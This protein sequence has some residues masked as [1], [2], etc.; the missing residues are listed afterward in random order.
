MGDLWAPCGCLHSLAGGTAAAPDPA[1]GCAGATGTPGWCFAVGWSQA[2]AVTA[3]Q[4]SAHVSAPREWLFPKEWSWI[5]R[6]KLQVLGSGIS[7]VGSAEPRCAQLQ[8][9]RTPELA[10]AAAQAGVAF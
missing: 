9:C 6:S 4:V 8:V 5:C 10:L 3:A 7:G 1:W 2:G